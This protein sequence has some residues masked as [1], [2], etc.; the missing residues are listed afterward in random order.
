M[1]ISYPVDIVKV[2]LSVST[3]VG[4]FPKKP[5]CQV[6]IAK[7]LGARSMEL[8]GSMPKLRYHVA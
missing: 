5:K 8:A 3:H 1:L 7:Y 2:L 4:R 6:E